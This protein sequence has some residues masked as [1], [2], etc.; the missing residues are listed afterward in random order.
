MKKFNLSVL[1][2]FVLSLLIVFQNCDK[3]DEETAR[4]RTLRILQSK[5]WEVS[6]V[7]V[8]VNTATE[9]A[10]WIDFTVAFTESS[11]TTK[12]HPTG[13]T[14]VWPGGAYTLSDDGTV[15]TRQSDQV[16]MLL[17]PISDTNFTAKFTV[18]PGTEIGPGRIA[19]LEGEYTFNMK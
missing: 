2:V 15:I 3:K 9:S 7:N 5:T 12:D 8:P 4:E 6:S 18:D 16:E 17:N 10:D 19:S 11:M 13:A 14:A 1:G